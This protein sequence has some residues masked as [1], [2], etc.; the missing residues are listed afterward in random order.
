M[1]VIGRFYNKRRTNIG[2]PHFGRFGNIGVQNYWIPELMPN[3]RYLSV[4]MK[5]A[6]IAAS[7]QAMPA[8]WNDQTAPT[9]SCHTTPARYA[10][11][12][13]PTP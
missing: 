7:T 3:N 1:N 13:P 5:S 2:L 10:P 8:S 6:N 11:A 12:E 4:L 9:P